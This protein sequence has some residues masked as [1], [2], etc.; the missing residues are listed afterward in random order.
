[1]SVRGCDRLSPDLARPARGLYGSPIG[2]GGNTPCTMCTAPERGSGTGRADTGGP[3]RPASFRSPRFPSSL[4]RPCRADR[5]RTGPRAPDRPLRPP[6]RISTLSR[7]NWSARS[8][9]PPGRHIRPGPDTVR[10]AGGSRRLKRSR[11]SAMSGRH[12]AIDCARPW[13]QRSLTKPPDSSVRE[14]AAQ[15]LSGAH[16]AAHSAIL[17]DITPT[18]MVSS[19]SDRFSTIAT[20][21]SRTRAAFAALTGAP[22]VGGR[23]KA[24]PGE[25]CLPPAS[26]PPLIS[27]KPG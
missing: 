12:G 7:T 26:T 13:A 17:H 27:G 11:L 3:G 21:P 19:P 25:H 10:S 8:D 6:A 20:T 2:T 16:T 23:P 15:H 24:A 14:C 9:R 5:S 18:G 1:M 4:R 22:P